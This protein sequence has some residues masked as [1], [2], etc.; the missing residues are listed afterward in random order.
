MKILDGIKHWFKRRA[1]LSF[2]KYLRKE[3]ALQG[4]KCTEE[5]VRKHADIHFGIDTR[6]K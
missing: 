3:L 4:L 1:R 2:E 6:G 5:I